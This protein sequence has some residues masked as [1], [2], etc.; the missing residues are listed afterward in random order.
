MARVRKASSIRQVGRAPWLAVLAGVVLCGALFARRAPDDSTREELLAAA[1]A[2]IAA[3]PIGALVTVDGA[4]YARI[5]SV[6]VRAPDSDDEQFVLWI[7]TQP[8]TRKVG[9][10]EANPKVALYFESD[11][12]GAYLSVSGLATVHRDEA[13][14]RRVS[15]RD[16]EARAGFWPDFPNDYVLIRVQPRWLE[17]IGFGIEADERSWRPQRVDFEP[18]EPR[19]DPR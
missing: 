3:D 17:V 18:P 14:A 15:W 11:D 4:G 9:Q 7:A 13:T 16:D 12:E 6:E 19:P 1:R 2:V 8:R 5:R 10:L